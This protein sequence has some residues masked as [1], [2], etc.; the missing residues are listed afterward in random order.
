MA[1]RLVTACEVPADDVR[2]NHPPEFVILQSMPRNYAA[3]VVMGAILIAAGNSPSAGA[4]LATSRSSTTVIRGVTTA[5]CTTPSEPGL[6]H[7]SGVTV[8]DP[9]PN[10]RLAGVE[11]RKSRGTLEVVFTMGGTINLG[12]NQFSDAVATYG[13]SFTVFDGEKR[14]G[15]LGWD[16]ILQDVQ[17][18]PGKVGN[19]DGV[20]TKVLRNASVRIDGSAATMVVPL[21]APIALPNT[22][23]WNA[24][25]V[26]SISETVG[27]RIS[28]EAYSG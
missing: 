10:A 14:L 6:S 27:G 21:K 3:L 26:R 16:S 7:I 4:T 18:D 1:L 23:R 19:Q 11:V 9:S 13:F 8:I 24:G 2:S 15:G 28:I 17:W 20:K 22:F 5:L 25:A 12:N